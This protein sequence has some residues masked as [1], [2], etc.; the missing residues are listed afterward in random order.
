MIYE[1]SVACSRPA[2]GDKLIAYDEAGKVM[3]I[4]E[5]IRGNDLVI[6]HTEDMYV[7]ESFTKP[8]QVHCLWLLKHKTDGS[9]EK[10]LADTGLKDSDGV[11]LSRDQTL[12]YVND[13][14]SHWVYSFTIQPDGRRGGF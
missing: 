4:A 12:L 3:T 5:G 7:T 11:A 9:F 6:G 13:Y 8:T 14:R 1:T 10:M 2:A